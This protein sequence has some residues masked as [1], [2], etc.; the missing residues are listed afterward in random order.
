THDL[1]N[2]IATESTGWIQP[3]GPIGNWYWSPTDGENHSW[4]YNENGQKSSYTDPRG[5]LT[6]YDYDLRNRLWKTHETVNTIPR[7]TETLYDTTSNK[8]DATFP[9]TRSQHWHDY[10]PFGQAWTFID[11]RN[12]TTNLSYEWGPM[13]KLLSVTTYRLKDGGGTEDQQT[14]FSYYLTGRS[15]TTLFPDGSSEYST[16]EFGQ[17][18]TWKT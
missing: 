6:T 13:K 9:D 17:L 16:Y 18:K 3:A 12:N 15:Q 10:D 8:T 2:R 5:R 11:E 4:T 1:Q 14:V 7:T